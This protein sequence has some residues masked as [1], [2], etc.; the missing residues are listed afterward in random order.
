MAPHVALETTLGPSST[1]QRPLTSF[2]IT[3]LAHNAALERTRR[4]LLPLKNNYKELPQREL[5][6]PVLDG[7]GLY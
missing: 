4:T 6:T 5:A 2:L 7:P 1:T 3:C